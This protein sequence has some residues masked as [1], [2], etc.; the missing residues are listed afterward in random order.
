MGAHLSP[1]QEGGGGVSVQQTAT[2]Y[3]KRGHLIFLFPV[4]VGVRHH[5]KIKARLFI[6]FPK[7]FEAIE[8]C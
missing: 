2:G 7:Q 1:R 8:L 6:R 3:A 5:N 4:P